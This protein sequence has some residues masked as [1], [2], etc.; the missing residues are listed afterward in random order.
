MF[1]GKRLIKFSWIAFKQ[2]TVLSLNIGMVEFLTLYLDSKDP[3]PGKTHTHTHTHE[4]QAIKLFDLT[5]IPY[6]HRIYLLFTSKSQLGRKKN[7]YY[8]KRKGD[9]QSQTLLRSKRRQRFAMQ[10][11]IKVREPFTLWSGSPS[12][13]SLHSWPALLVPFGRTSCRSRSRPKEGTGG[14]AG[15]VLQGGGWRRSR[16]GSPHPPAA[17]GWGRAGPRRSQAWG[18]RGGTRRPRA[19]SPRQ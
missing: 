1:Y 10:D 19:P 13:S 7:V 3:V 4:L 16:R 17:A 12:S 14:G 18:W 9:G 15:S 2:K 8:K 5:L 11:E 6:K